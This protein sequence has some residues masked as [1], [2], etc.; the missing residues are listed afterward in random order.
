M[1]CWTTEHP[2]KSP[3]RL[4]LGLVGPQRCGPEQK[5]TIKVILNPHIRFLSRDAEESGFANSLGLCSRSWMA[6]RPISRHLNNPLSSFRSFMLAFFST[7]SNSPQLDFKGHY[8]NC[9][10]AS[11]DEVIFHAGKRFSLVCCDF[12][13]PQMLIGVLK[14]QFYFN[15]A[16]F[17]GEKTVFPSKS[18]L[19]LLTKGS[20]WFAP[21]SLL[22]GRAPARSQSCSSWRELQTSL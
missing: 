9:K 17:G 15:I 1:G 13:A 21:I 22:S 18:Q 6:Q 16:L 19:C 4:S 8:M 2:W 12:C 7:L 3:W 20:L 10:D 14:R 11:R 5:P